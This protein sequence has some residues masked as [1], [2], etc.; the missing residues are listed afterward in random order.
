MIAV[1]EML[2]NPDDRRTKEQKYK[3]A[4]LTERTFYRWMKDERYI[5]YINTLIDKYTD[6]ET[7]EVWKSLVRNCKMGKEQSIK[8]FFEMKGMYKQHHEITG[9]GGGPIQT[10]AT[11]TFYIPD[12][13]RGDNNA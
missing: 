10:A 4:G 3:A 8:L 12:N 2:V 13:G 5:K 11:V 6:A 9:K 7:P 1:A